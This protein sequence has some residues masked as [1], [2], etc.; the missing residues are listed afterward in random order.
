[1]VADIFAIV[2]YAFQNTGMMVSYIIGT[3]DPF[4]IR[5]VVC[6][7]SLPINVIMYTFV[8]LSVEKFIYS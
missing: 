1:M 4:M 6:I 5:C 3:Q 2:V 7:F 8:I